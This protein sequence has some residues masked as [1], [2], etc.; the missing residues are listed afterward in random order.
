MLPERVDDHT[1]LVP[2]LG[3]RVLTLGPLD[4]SLDV[5]SRSFGQ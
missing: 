1:G 3:P 4:L 2:P 5:A